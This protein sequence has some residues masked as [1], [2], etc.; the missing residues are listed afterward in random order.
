MI[1]RMGMANV[2]KRSVKQK[3]GTV[4]VKRDITVFKCQFNIQGEFQIKL[5]F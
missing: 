5:F 1:D 4:K 2:Y 3:Q